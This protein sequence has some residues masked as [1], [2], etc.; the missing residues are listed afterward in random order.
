MPPLLRHAYQVASHDARL[1]RRFPMLRWAVLG[2]VCIPAIYAFI[3]L[4]SVWDPNARTANLPVALVQEDQGFDYRGQTINMGSELVST[5]ES[6]KSFRYVRFNDGE[7]ARR[8][9]RAGDM[10]FA[11][12]VPRDFSLH[13]VPG[14]EAGGGKLVIYTSEGN[15][16]NGAGFAKRF[17][18]ELAHQVN[19]SL[20]EKRW[21]LVLE[22]AAGSARNL[23]TLRT[24]MQQLQDASTQLADGSRQVKA[25]GQNLST[26]LDKLAPGG[27]QL[28]D[29][30][31]Q[32][33]GGIRQMQAKLPG[34]ESLQQLRSGAVSLTKGSA[35]LATGLDKLHVGAE[36]LSAGTRELKEQSADIPLLGSR[37]AQAAGELENGAEQLGTGL[38]R[39]RDAQHGLAD[40]ARK[41]EGGVSTLTEGVAQIGSSLN[42]MAGRLPPEA[43]LKQWSNGLTDSARGSQSLAAGL[44]QLDDGVARLKTGI[45]LINDTLPRDNPEMDGNPKGL[46]ISVQPEVEVVAPVANNGT[47]FA[48]NFVPLAL[49]VGAVMSAFLFPLRQVPASLSGLSNLALVAGKLAYPALI[50]VVQAIVMLLMLT[51]VLDIAIPSTLTFA[52]TLVCASLTFLAIIFTL[53]RLF[54]D[55]GKVLSVLLLILQ[56]SSAGALMPVELT[57]RAFQ[58][59]H[60]LLPFSWVVK[61]FRASLFGA[62]EGAWLLP[63]SVAILSGMAGLLVA[64]LA[65]RWKPVSDDDYRPAIDI[66]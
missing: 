65:G 36:K 40:G 11:L 5:L 1:F 59:L 8:A 31:R 61:A 66:L 2:V 49:W 43:Q 25:G 21:A 27:N 47:G 63:W 26:A 41:L 35:E 7:S 24:S 22:K 37:L 64:T 50:S 28:A 17:A 39:A 12:I 34:E 53:L 58:I 62:Y 10:V 45:T 9:V 33:G 32:I 18:P 3:Y 55:I 20:N 19:E 38:E 46:A 6:Q 4:S 57:S 15:S 29:G 14:N 23:D 44:A 54:G 56:L 30:L 13:A 48:V 52:L 16:Y 51:F 42:T 60:P